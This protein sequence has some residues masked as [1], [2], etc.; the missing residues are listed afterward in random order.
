MAWKFHRRAG[1]PF[2]VLY[3]FLKLRFSSSLTVF[4][5]KILGP[6]VQIAIQ[7]ILVDKTTTLFTTQ[8]ASFLYSPSI[9]LVTASPDFNDADLASIVSSQ[10][11][12][13]LP[14]FFSQ[15]LYRFFKVFEV[16]FVFL[17]RKAKKKHK[18]NGTIRSLCSVF[19]RLLSFKGAS[20]DHNFLVRNAVA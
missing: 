19:R 15:I 20:I 9:K 10:F 8:K 6:V 12:V 18:L 11:I 1:F 7:W 13:F 3:N 17:K 14:T 2:E 4:Q 16:R 5:S